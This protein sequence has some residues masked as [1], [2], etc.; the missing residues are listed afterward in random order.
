MRL[1]IVGFARSVHTARYLQLLEGM[2][3]EVHLF[4]STVSPRPHPDLS[5]VVL[6]SSVP[7]ETP[8]GRGVTVVD[9][10]EGA[11]TTLSWRAEQLGRLVDEIRPDV[12]HSH[13]IQHGGALVERLRRSRGRVGAPW[14]VTN[15]GSDI[16]W[17][18]RSRRCAPQ[19]REV[20]GACDYYGAECHRDV[21]LARAF[22]LRGEVVGV[23]PVAGGV[24]LTRVASL[25]APGPTS[26]RR[27][28]AVKGVAGGSGQGSIA[29]AAIER[30][31]DLLAGWE[32]CGY[33][34]HPGL[35]EIARKMA[36]H[37]GM[38]Y[39]RLSLDGGSDSA[40]DDLLAMH[41]RARVSLALNWSDALSTSLLEAMAMGSFPV[42]SSGSCGCEITPPGRGAMFVPAGD[43]DA[44]A[45]ALGRA[46][47]DDALVDAAAVINAGA[48]AEH[49]DRRRTRARVVDMYERIVAQ[50]S[51][52]RA[53]V[54]R[55][56]LG[57]G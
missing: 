53:S 16:L 38:A 25:R 28:I 56:S 6:H 22:G 41:G 32:L 46:L 37:A 8:P 17:Y 57:V 47:T 50:S 33:K 19:I 12:V 43:L 44:V 9:P 2:D 29:L 24:D 51:V 5:G 55:P 15:W 52:V 23:W 10:P 48:A 20:L 4:D 21:A 27:A 18:G 13:E 7:V 54:A 40:H 49:L 3:W 26:C 36:E 11:S 34:M 45:G 1:V 31:A 39:T 30:C 35:D 14:L 42:H